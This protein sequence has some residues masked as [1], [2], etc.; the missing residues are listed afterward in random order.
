MRPVQALLAV[1]GCPSPRQGP[2]GSSSRG[3]GAFCR[4][5]LWVSN[6]GV[7]LPLLVF[8]PAMQWVM[9]E[10]GLAESALSLSPSWRGRLQQHPLHLQRGHRSLAGALPRA[11]GGGGRSPRGFSALLSNCSSSEQ[12]KPA[13]RLRQ[14]GSAMPAW[15]LRSSCRDKSCAQEKLLLISQHLKAL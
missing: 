10:D 15:W 8:P 13:D 3:W 6:P 2:Q 5:N 7:T 12:L 14:R 9:A 1:A 4:E 11:R